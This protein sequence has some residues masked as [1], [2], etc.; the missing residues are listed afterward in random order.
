MIQSPC[1][2]APVQDMA[3]YVP[4]VM[5]ELQGALID[6]LPEV[7]AT[8]A[9]ALGSLLRSM[10]D[11]LSKQVMPWL[12]QTLKSDVRPALPLGQAVHAFWSC[13]C[14]SSELSTMTCKQFSSMH[15]TTTLAFAPGLLEYES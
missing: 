2:R 12:L 4:L 15:V 14:T 5:P 6:P 3:P 7:R 8:A 1:A 9:R 11:D 13:L 10:G